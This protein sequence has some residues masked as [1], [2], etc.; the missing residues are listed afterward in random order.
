MGL[1]DGILRASSV[2]QDSACTQLANTCTFSVGGDGGWTQRP[3]TGWSLPTGSS[4]LHA[5]CVWSSGT[6][7]SQAWSV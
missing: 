3:V 2:S 4:K 6:K 1:P 5:W 7:L